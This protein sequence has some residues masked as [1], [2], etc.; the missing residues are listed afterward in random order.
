MKHK[1][2]KIEAELHALIKA[3]A[4]SQG[5]FIN[6]FLSHLYALYEKDKIMQQMFSECNK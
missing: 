4:K 1:H 2:L 6:E 5:M 3:E